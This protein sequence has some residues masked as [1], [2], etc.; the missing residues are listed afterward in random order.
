MRNCYTMSR[1]F[2][3]YDF[4]LLFLDFLLCW[5]MDAKEGIFVKLGSA[6]LYEINSQSINDFLSLSF[7]SRRFPRSY[8]FL[9]P[10]FEWLMSLL[11]T[12]DELLKMLFLILLNYNRDIRWTLLLMTMFLLVIHAFYNNCSINILQQWLC[13]LNFEFIGNVCDE[14]SSNGNSSL[15]YSDMTSSKKRINGRCCDSLD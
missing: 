5:T 12:N 14:L 8:D 1:I 2:R 7:P 15:R 13:K 9:L 10:I 3:W 11:A 4:D 6:F